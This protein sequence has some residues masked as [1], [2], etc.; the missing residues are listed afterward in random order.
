[1]KKLPE[2]IIDF[3]VHLFPDK[4]FD[5]I[6]NVFETG[7]GI[8]IPCKLYYRECIEYLR[9]RNV[10]LIVFSNYA[11]KEGIA[12]PMNRWNLQ[13][14]DEF[15]YVYCFAPYHP[16]DENAMAYME[17]ML[18]HPR[19]IGTKLHLQV[20]QIH[21]YDERLF[22]LYEMIMDKGKRILLHIG[23][24]PIGNEFV[25]V[26]GFKR[27]LDRYPDLPVNIPH[28]GGLEFREFM[29]LLDEHPN[30]YLDT[31]YTFWPDLPFTFNLGPDYLEAY[32]SRIVYGSD[33]PNVML[34][35]EGE[36]DYLLQ[37]DLSEAF[38]QN[39]FYKNGIKL[40]QEACPTP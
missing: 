31:S 2:S 3:H 34:P 40:I 30:L 8:T 23:T 18:S 16:G 35:R 20:Q 13:V 27:V 29:D 39:V 6:W 22:P 21:P 4:G 25:G 10:D 26:T 32:K 36:I 5:A 37:L 1:M 28:M 38:Y 7:Y 12:E 14:L 15:A 17:Q 11:H 24:G 9:A 19:V 33:F